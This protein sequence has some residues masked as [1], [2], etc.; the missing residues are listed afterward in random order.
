LETISLPFASFVFQTLGLPG[1]I[2]I[3]WWWDHKAQVK[4]RED[5][6][7]QH[8]K[9]RLEHSKS[10]EAHGKEIA[11]ILAQYRDDVS[12]IKQLYQNNVD[13]V[14]AYDRSLERI[15]KLYQE[16][17]N[18][19]ALNTQMSTKLVV[20]INSNDYCPMVRAAGPNR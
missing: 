8:E 9:E 7:V 1:L 12:S 11:A 20:A 2:F 13:L 17:L 18:V 10:R 4:Q 14:H 5:D 3:I 19:I 6:Q 15:E 16:T